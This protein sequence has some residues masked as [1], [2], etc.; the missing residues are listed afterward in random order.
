MNVA[1]ALQ[2]TKLTNPSLSDPYD[3]A[4]AS[5][6]SVNASFGFGIE[7]RRDEYTDELR[8]FFD[9]DWRKAERVGKPGATPPELG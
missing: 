4:S 6:S 1:G 5:D 9:F 3:E 8:R 2:G 7:R